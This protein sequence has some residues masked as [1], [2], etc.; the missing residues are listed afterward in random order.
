MVI[1][2]ISV[3]IPTLNRSDLICRAVNSALCQTF[4]DIEVIVVID[5][6]D[7]ATSAA[8]KQIEDERV[9]VLALKENVGGSDARNAGV[10]A[11]RFGWIA[12]LDDDDQWLPEKLQRQV[13]FARGLNNPLPVI[14]CLLIARTE[15]CDYVWPKK[16]PNPTQHISEYLFVRNSFTTGHGEAWLQ[17]STLLIKK[18][19][20]EAVPFKS[21]LKKHQDSDWALR[22][23]LHEGVSFEFV[24]EPLAIVYFSAQRKTVSS[25]YNWKYSLDWLR[26]S[27]NLFTPKAYS[28]FVA[29]QIALEAS[30]KRQWSSFVSLFGEMYRFG[31]PRL[32]DIAYYMGM[33]FV[34]T[35][36]QFKIRHI[37]NKYGRTK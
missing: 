13:N 37:F 35:S 17:P 18:Q 27:R 29:T 25:N 31:R 23:A 4:K 11:A 15:V 6:P 3:V 8:L 34:P 16:L 7:E 2:K 36:L 1:D 21:G 33:W 12:F 30:R 20:L 14:C 28:G 10:R 24:T 22:A 9:R 26:E 32:F 19:L 5:G